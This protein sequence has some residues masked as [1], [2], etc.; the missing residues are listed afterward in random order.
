MRIDISRIKDETGARIEREFSLECSQLGLD[1]VAEEGRGPV[2]AKVAITNIGNRTFMVEG[3]VESQMEFTCSR[4]LTPF[5]YHL[6]G[7]FSEEY[8]PKD[9]ERYDQWRERE[10]SSGEYPVEEEVRF[11]DHTYLEISDTLRDAF[12]LAVPMKIVCK[13]DCQGICPNCGQSKNDVQCDCKPDNTDLRWAALKE[14]L[15]EDK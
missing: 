7:G 9:S 13:D 12:Y 8:L 6:S 11:Y 4:C 5:T 1:D 2:M 3:R 15:E 10:E 14:L